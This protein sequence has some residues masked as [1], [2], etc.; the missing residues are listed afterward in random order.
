[1]EAVQT[2]EHPTFETVWAALMENRE[3]LKETDR[4]MKE[5]AK[6][7][8]ERAAQLDKEMGRLGNRLGE[9][10]EHMVRPNLVKRFR[11]LGFAFTEAWPSAFI[12]EDDNVFGE[13]DL[14]LRN[15]DKVMLV[16]VKTKPNTDDITEHVKR[17]GRARTYADLHN[18]KRKYL[19]AIAGMVLSKSVK[20]FALKNGFFV[21]E[22]SGETFTV[23]AP[24]GSYSVREW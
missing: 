13:V 1:M 10:I 16:E 23:T 14:S 3:Q 12:A 18:D 24:E 4:L 2:V 22:P 6:R 19:G 7:Q 17:M 11:E 20:T 8:E 15:G 9:M 21:I 5:N